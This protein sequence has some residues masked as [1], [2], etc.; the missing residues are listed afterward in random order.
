MTHQL[1]GQKF[2]RLRVIKKVGSSKTNSHLIWLC[3]CDCGNTTSVRSDQLV[4]G[5]TRSCGCLGK[6]TA[7]KNVTKCRLPEGEAAFNQLFRNMKRNAKRRG[8]VWELTKKEV[9][10]LTKQDCFYCGREPSQI[11]SAPTYNG[12]YV[13]NGID[14]FDSDLGYV[15]TNVVPCCWD[16]NKRKGTRNGNELLAWI[17]TVY[18]H[19]YKGT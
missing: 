19:V 16:C 12:S 5:R 14:R 7:K 8:Y 6:E 1:T 3:E 4:L 2:E 9:R 10:R 17:K 15:C 18:E 11:S 13:Y